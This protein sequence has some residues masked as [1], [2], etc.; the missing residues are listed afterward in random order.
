MLCS[1]PLSSAIWWCQYTLTRL[2]D[3]LKPPR[4]FGSVIQSAAARCGCCHR[5]FNESTIHHQCS[6]TIVSSRRP[7][8]VNNGL[9]MRCSLSPSYLDGQLSIP[10]YVFFQV[11]L[12]PTSQTRVLKLVLFHGNSITDEGF[13]ERPF[14]T[15]SPSLNLCR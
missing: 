7:T 13:H 2:S 1:V 8:M 11:R 3:N 6:L 9:S 12:P 5:C 4:Q 14:H 15:H 10:A